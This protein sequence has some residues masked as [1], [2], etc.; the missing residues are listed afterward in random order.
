MSNIS[1][2]FENAM[3]RLNAEKLSES[4]RKGPNSLP[5]ANFN[6]VIEADHMAYMQ[7]N[8]NFPMG[9]HWFSK[10]RFGRVL[11]PKGGQA[12]VEI[13]TGRI[14][15][16]PRSEGDDTWDPVDWDVLQADYEY[17]KRRYLLQGYDFPRTIAELI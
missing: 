6:Q 5:L 9:G 17:W 13:S 12:P 10:K 15:W 7:V 1:M 3:K 4:R 8:P 2:N 16:E 11:H 14:V